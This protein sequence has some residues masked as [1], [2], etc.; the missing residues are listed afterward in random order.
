MT[1]IK[2]DQWEI[3]HDTV[4]AQTFLYRSIWGGVCGPFT[5]RTPAATRT[6]AE[7]AALRHDLLRSGPWRVGLDG[8]DVAPAHHITNTTKTTNTTNATVRDM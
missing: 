1:T 4:A 6:D 8:V 3:V 5:T 2:A 7:T